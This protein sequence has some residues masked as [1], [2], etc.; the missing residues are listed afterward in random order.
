MS[1]INGPM[2]F[3]EHKET[4][5]VDLE[6][7]GREF[8]SLG[9]AARDGN[10]RLVEEMFLGDEDAREDT[11]KIVRLR[12]LFILRYFHRQERVAR[13]RQPAPEDPVDPKGEDDK[14]D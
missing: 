5:A 8:L 2:T 13:T 4:T 9:I 7:I 10:M 3:A 6:S 14:G 11:S 1:D 12:E